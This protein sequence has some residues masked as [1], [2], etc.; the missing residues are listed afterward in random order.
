[1][2]INYN[3]PQEEFWAGEFGDS[4]IG[5][6]ESADLLA[7]NIALFAHIFSSMGKVPSS[8]LELGANI[9]MNVR[10]IQKLSPSAEI[11]GIEI[12]GQASK[13]LEETGC[14]V[15]K[16]S[17]KECDTNNPR[18][19]HAFLASALILKPAGNLIENPQSTI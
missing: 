2:T 5:R 9:G 12:N 19:A 10:A 7:S 1:M 15:I 13:I 16:S 14:T 11:T 6:N 17:I 3:S 18:F 8:I 4:Y